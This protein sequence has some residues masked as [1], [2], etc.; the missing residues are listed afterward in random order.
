[1]GDEERLGGYWVERVTNSGP[2]TGIVST[3]NK[4]KV[5]FFH[6]SRGFKCYLWQSSARCNCM[7]VA[8]AWGI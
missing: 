3:K 7:K 5:A 8:W 4:K 6:R 1:M 2:A